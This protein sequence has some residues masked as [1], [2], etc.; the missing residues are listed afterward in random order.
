M[1]SLGGVDKHTFS[2]YK[3]Q[4]LKVNKR[5]N[6]TKALDDTPTNEERAAT[7]LNVDSDETFMVVSEFVT[8]TGMFSD[9]INSSNVYYQSGTLMLPV[10]ITTKGQEVF[11]TEGLIQ[12]EIGYQMSRKYKTHIG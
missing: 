8:S 11:N 12:I 9:L 4:S 10:I 5:V 3:S 1:N 7:T 2:S 6:Y